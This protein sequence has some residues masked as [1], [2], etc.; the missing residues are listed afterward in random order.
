MSFSKVV[1]CQQSIYEFCFNYTI[2]INAHENI[3]FFKLVG[4]QAVNT[5][6]NFIIYDG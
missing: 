4:F 2:V 5:E 3:D 1:L 6:F